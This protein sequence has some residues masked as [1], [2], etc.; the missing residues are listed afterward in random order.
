MCVHVCVCVCVCVCLC[1]CVCYSYDPQIVISGLFFSVLRRLEAKGIKLSQQVTGNFFTL[2]IKHYQAQT[3]IFSQIL[4]SD[5]PS[6]WFCLVW[7]Y[8]ISTI[9]G[10][11]MPNLF[12]YI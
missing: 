11:L 6:V 1:V 9:V 7:F 5:I 3:A 2:L 4:I 12:L 8:A 10:Y